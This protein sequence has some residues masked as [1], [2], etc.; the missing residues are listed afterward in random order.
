M[1]EFRYRHGEIVP[2]VS[3]F[4]LLSGN[5]NRVL[6]RVNRNPNSAWQIALGDSTN[7]QLLMPASLNGEPFVIRRVDIGHVICEPI[8]Y[9]GLAGFALMFVEAS[10][11]DPPLG[12]LG[13]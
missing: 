5:P 4:L 11:F 10:C 9:V 6:F 13:C 12:R 2:S 3:P 1:S 8:F 7:P